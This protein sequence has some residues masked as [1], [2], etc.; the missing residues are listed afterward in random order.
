M[1]EYERSRVAG[2]TRKIRTCTCGSVWNAP[3][4][5]RVPV[6]RHEDQEIGGTVLGEEG[7]LGDEGAVQRAVEPRLEDPDGSA[8]ASSR[9]VSRLCSA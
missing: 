9:R 2:R 1:R 6:E 8:A 4:W 7:A 5:T 3:A